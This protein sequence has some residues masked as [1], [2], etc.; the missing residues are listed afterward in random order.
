VGLFYVL[1]SRVWVW[2]LALVPVLTLSATSSDLLSILGRSEI[3]IF[4]RF[5]S[6]T[7]LERID[8]LI[9][10]GKDFEQIQQPDHL[11]GLRCKLARVQ[12][13]QRAPPL[14]RVGV[15]LDHQPDAAGVDH[16]HVAQ[17]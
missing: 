15:H 16:A 8:G 11:E 2:A 14:F 10:V 3:S 7:S 17:I 4:L 12:E 5:E 1:P 9:L 6:A 13:L